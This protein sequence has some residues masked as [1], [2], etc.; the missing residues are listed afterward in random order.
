MAA[1]EAYKEQPALE[2]EESLDGAEE[3]MLAS[4]EEQLNPSTRLAI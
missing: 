4:Q 2:E 1:A 3:E